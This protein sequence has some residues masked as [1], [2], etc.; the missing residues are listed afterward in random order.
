MDDVSYA[1]RRGLKWLERTQRSDGSWP[2]DSASSVLHG[3]TRS[4][5]A[6]IGCGFPADYPVLLRGQR[7]LTRPEAEA[8][9]Y[10][11]FW[12]LGALSELQ[13]VP[14]EI[15][16]HDFDV[17][18][19]SIAK[20]IRLDRKLNYH[21][22]LL[23][24]AATTRTANRFPEVIA[25]LETQLSSNSLTA[26]PAL[27]GYV[28]LERSGHLQSAQTER[29]AELVLKALQDQNG[30]LHINGLVVETSFFVFNACRSTILGSDLRIRL[31]VLGAIRWILSRQSSDG[32]WPV[33][34]PVY[35]GDP[36][37]A[38]YCTG[39][40]TRALAEYL[41][42]YEPTHLAEVFLPDWRLRIFCLTALRWSTMILLSIVFA[43][44]LVLVLPHGWNA[45]AGLLGA[46]ASIIEI[47]MFGIR[48]RRYLSF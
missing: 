24:C 15:L 13:G 17:V 7:W 6:F 31:A 16:E 19:Q 29:V 20:G 47:S 34:P 27:W 3:T 2:A 26:T 32:S 18:R 43:A 28:S 14:P 5:R 38:A 48:L 9:I 11:Y 36:Q 45:I 8:A 4:L 21:A 10:Q 41:R 44:G 40:A 23:D 33:E 46:V 25:D 1:V 22:F 39:I 12:R 42:R 37:C 35:N 30:S